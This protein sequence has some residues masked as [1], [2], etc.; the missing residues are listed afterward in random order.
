M[1]HVL[2][3]NI[4]PVFAIL[5]LGRAMGRGGVAGAGE[6]RAINRISFLV[7]QPPLI[8]RLLTNADFGNFRRAAL[9]VMSPGNDWAPL[10]VLNAAGPSGAMAFALALLYKVRTDAIAPVIIWTSVLSLFSLA[11]LA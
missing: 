3:Q 4:L 2:T 5:A 11:W 6:A 9:A 7:L 10:F 8:F 1:L